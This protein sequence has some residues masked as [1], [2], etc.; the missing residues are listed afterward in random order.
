MKKI[1]EEQISGFK[2]IVKDKIQFSNFLIRS[3]VI[4]VKK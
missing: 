1:R 2:L 4:I 3:L